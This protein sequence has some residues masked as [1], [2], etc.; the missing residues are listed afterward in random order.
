MKKFKLEV[1]GIKYEVMAESLEKVEGW[2]GGVP[3][4]WSKNKDKVK[5]ED[6]S[7]QLKEVE[8]DCIKRCELDKFLLDNFDK[9][10]AMVAA[11]GK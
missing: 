5:E 8:D 3:E 4:L 6:L 10:K 1:D 11:H 7:V 9:L 2:E